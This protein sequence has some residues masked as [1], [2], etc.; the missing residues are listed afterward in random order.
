MKRQ[1]RVINVNKRGIHGQRDIRWWQPTIISCS[2][3]PAATMKSLVPLPSR[4]LATSPLKPY[5]RI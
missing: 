2:D 4:T 3:D 5:L 1:T